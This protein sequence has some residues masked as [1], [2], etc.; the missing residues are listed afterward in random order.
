MPASGSSYAIPAEWVTRHQVR[1][2]G[3]HGIA[4]AAMTQSYAKAMG[5]LQ[6]QVTLI[7]LQLGN[8]CSI[9]AV[10]N[11][12]SVDTSMGMTPLEGLV[13]GTRSGDI[14]PSVVA[15]LAR[16]ESVEAETIEQWLNERSGLR[17]V[18]NLSHDIRQLLRAEQEG[19]QQA[20]IAIELFCYRVRKYIG[21]YLAVLNGAEAIV[22]GGGIG[23]HAPAIRA[24]ICKGMEWCGIHIDDVL[25][26]RATDPH[27]G[28]VLEISATPATIPI[29]VIGVDEETVIAQETCREVA[30]KAGH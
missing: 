24:R 19:H 13:M 15:Y 12:R 14:D 11:G 18:S 3:F 5:R 25:N 26:Q 2:F 28:Q 9:T 1:R 16:R 30:S 23:E 7:T 27:R 29:Y 22:F 8:G 6:E 17:G 20:A 21:A 4:H 10:R